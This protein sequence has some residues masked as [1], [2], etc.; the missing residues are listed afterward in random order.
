MTARLT[1]LLPFAGIAVIVFA[2]AKL[3]AQYI[4]DYDLTGSGRFAWTIVYISTSCLIA[5]GLGI[6]DQEDPREAARSSL[7]AA[8]SAPLAFGLLQ[9][10]VGETLLPRFVI[11]LSAPCYLVLFLV[12]GELTRK[13]WGAA[14]ESAGIVAI[15]DDVEEREFVPDLAGPLQRAAELRV[16]SRPGDVGAP[17]DLTATVRA[18]GATLLVLGRRA[19]DDREL[20]SEAAELH[21][22][23]LQ[24]RGI[25][26]F[27]EEWIG[28]IPH[29]E[30]GQAILMFD[31][32]EIHRPGYRRGSRLLDISIAGV[33]L[34][35]LALATPLV[36]LGNLIGNRGPL[37]YR[38]SRVGRDGHIFEMLK[39]RSMRPGESTGQWTSADDDRITMFGRMLRLSHLDELPQVVNILKGD[40]SVVGPRPEQP[41]YVE[42]LS[43]K[44]PYYRLRHLV[45]PGLTGWAQVNYP[46][47]ADE[48]DALEKL[49]YEFW[50]LRHQSLPLDF[51]I[52][53]R[54]VRHVLGFK[55][56]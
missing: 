23:G 29:R 35:P 33:A 44:I 45:R 54:T 2:L 47:G 4:G 14:A 32:A 19:L 43:D 12:S 7:V 37:L 21:A 22:R 42:L 51:R 30:L 26:A 50:Y 27:Y 40:L 53:A 24:V 11:A 39:F 52:I 36:V 1:K 38:Q 25:L 6:P 56:R 15:L 17:G 3:H 8:V 20:L 41:R 5:Y 55:G 10:A 28:K 13:S 48:K 46:Y 18:S 9:L 34:I 49:Q 16:V 31:I